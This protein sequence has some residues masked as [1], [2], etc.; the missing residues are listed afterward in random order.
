MNVQIIQPIV[1]EYRIPFFKTLIENRE[2]KVSVFASK[3]LP[4]DQSIKTAAGIGPSFRV[5]H[6]CTG[7]FNNRLMWQKGMALD[8]NSKRGDVLV[9]CGNA[10]FLSNYPLLWKAKRRNIATVWWGIGSMPSQNRLRYLLRA[11]IMR[12]MDVIL[13][14]TEREKQDFL[15][16]GFPSERVFAINNAIDQ[17]PLQA[18]TAQ[19]P[20]SRLAAFQHEHG[21]TNKLVFLFCGRLSAKAR[22]DLAI[23]ALAQLLNRNKNCLLVLI[24]DGDQ[25]NNLEKL[26]RRLNVMESIRWLGAIYDQDLM[27]PWFLSAKAFVYP[28][29]IGLSILHAMGYALPVITHDNLANQSPEVAALI[30]GENGILYAEN[31]SSDLSSKMLQMVSDETLRQAMSK[32]ALFTAR[33]EFTLPEMVRRF[34]EAVHAAASMKNRLNS[35]HI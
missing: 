21:I 6:P 29:Y 4:N 28:G 26:A 34:W 19:W 17:T 11:R 18:A 8:P 22:V 13:L 9:V 25:R 27:A 3:Q 16:I 5:D 12:W 33:E 15:R 31:D 23:E 24:G 20:S 10:R 32:R 14:Y 1:P 35:H 7:F 30:E 2:H